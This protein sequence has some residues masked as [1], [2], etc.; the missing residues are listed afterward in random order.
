MKIVGMKTR[1]SC[2]LATFAE[3]L[4]LRQT[5]IEVKSSGQE[6][7]LH[8]GKGQSRKTDMLLGTPNKS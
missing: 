8:T 7:P 3:I 2:S 4:P 6:C 1:Q 5:K